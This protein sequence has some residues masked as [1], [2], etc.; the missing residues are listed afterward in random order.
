M[1]KIIFYSILILFACLTCICCVDNTY[2]LVR[3][4][5]SEYRKNILVYSDD[6]YFVSLMS[7]YREN[8]YAK[9]GISNEKLDFTIISLSI[10]NADAKHDISYKTTINEIEYNGKLIN[11]PYDNSYV[12]D[13]GTNATETTTVDIQFTIDGQTYNF[14][15]NK[16]NADWEISGDQALKISC[17]NFKDY[18]RQSVVDNKFNGECYVKVVHNDKFSNQFYWYVE[19]LAG[20]NTY[21]IIINPNTGD[22]LAQNIS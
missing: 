6:D 3:E 14:T 12:I 20:K 5:I 7:G 4:N 13:I 1:K 9:D 18:I 22:I 8:N 21:A 2:N 15:L 11:N 10:N 19:I 16:I 17:H